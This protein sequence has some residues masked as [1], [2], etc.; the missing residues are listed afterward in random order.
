MN[1]RSDER[2]ATQAQARQ[3]YCRILIQKSLDIVSVIDRDGVIRFVNPAVQR[4]LGFS[5]DD[6]TGNSLFDLLHPG[7]VGRVKTGLARIADGLES[8]RPAEFRVRHKDGSWRTLEAI[9]RNLTDDS[10]ASEIAVDTRDVT[11]RKHTLRALRQSR[12]FARH[13]AESVPDA[14]VVYDL[15]QG[16]FVYAN[17]DVLG[18]Q[19]EQIRNMDRAQ[20]A[21]LVHP[22]D[23]VA[24]NERLRKLERGRE[25]EVFETEYRLK[26]RDGRWHWISSR[27]TIFKRTREGTPQQTICAVR[28]I[29]ARKQADS[30]IEAH[31]AELRR[32]REE[33]RALAARLL[34]VAE[35]E[36][37]ALS[38]E[39]HDDLNQ[40][41]AIFAI[42]LETIASGLSPAHPLRRELELLRSRLVELTED[43][44][45][46]AY[47]LRPSI[48]DDLGL[49]PALRSYCE[50]FKSR[51]RVSVTFTH[52][53]LP[54]RLQPENA[55]C[56]YRVTQEALRNIAKHARTR[57]AAVVLSG[58]NGAVVLT[59]KDWGAGFDPDGAQ[60]N[61]LGIVG[62]GERVRLAGG[63]FEVRS[64]PGH[65][66]EIEV[67]IPFAAEAR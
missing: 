5:P 13:I 50:Q 67:R 37:K 15:I 25:G 59:I 22:A 3:D 61:G 30:D 31:E 24:L 44:R 11:Q 41:L 12:K 21:T 64:R 43:V 42:D 47:Q 32:S 60:R 36:R 6:L 63:S 58:D 53:G 66:T 34:T 57:R 14:L 8:G 48:L 2:W 9:G 16:R 51:E 40:R 54:E 27:D 52:A 46:M 33:L 7:D 18:H 23:R 35:E 55:L 26:D 28:D 20:F 17:R 62:M 39:L 56:L 19:P 65:G 4:V 10:A 29:T 45:R 1:D 38:R 49:V